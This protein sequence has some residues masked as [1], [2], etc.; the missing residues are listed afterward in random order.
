MNLQ[1]FLEAYYGLKV[2]TIIDEYESKNSNAEEIFDIGL[3]KLGEKELKELADK[4]NFL[5]K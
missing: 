4:T 1:E 5:K 3:K 2:V